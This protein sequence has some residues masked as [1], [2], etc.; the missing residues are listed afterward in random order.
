MGETRKL[1]RDHD[2]LSEQ[3]SRIV[4]FQR[5]SAK[6]EKWCS[7]VLPET[8]LPLALNIHRDNDHSQGDSASLFDSGG[9]YT[10]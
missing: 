8:L 4:E 2:N 1:T 7:L 3:E 6:L 10:C 5:F 9:S